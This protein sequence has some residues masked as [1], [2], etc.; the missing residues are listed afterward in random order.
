MM[1]FE[2]LR[3]YAVYQELS[4]V[5]E[6][7][8][9]PLLMTNFSTE[10]IYKWRDIL[11]VNLLPMPSE[12]YLQPD[13]KVGIGLEHPLIKAFYANDR[14]KTNYENVDFPAGAYDEEKIDFLKGY[15]V[16]ERK[17]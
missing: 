15:I 7:L 17:R 8:F 2:V 1:Y 9:V 14:I 4:S 13:K 5:E 3:H 11:S 16:P 12:T 6:C 10:N